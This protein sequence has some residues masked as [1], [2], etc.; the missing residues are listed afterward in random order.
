MDSLISHLST[1]KPENLD[2]GI[3]TEKYNQYLALLL[4]EDR[5]IVEGI[6][7]RLRFI[8]YEELLSALNRSLDDF[9]S[10][11]KS[12]NKV[13]VAFPSHKIGSENWLVAQV[14]HRLEALNPQLISGNAILDSNCE[15]YHILFIDDAIYTGNNWCGFI[16]S[17]TYD[18]NP[19]KQTENKNRFHYHVVVPFRTED[20]KRF[21]ERNAGFCC[22]PYFYQ[23]EVLSNCRNL[24]PTE[25]LQDRFKMESTICSPTYFAHKIANEFG[26]WPQILVDGYLPHT[27]KNFGTILK[28][29]P[30]KEFL[31]KK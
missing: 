7:S 14:W 6:I 26:C 3:D 2:Y 17:L 30:N 31:S 12:L 18:N 4:P 11:N 29:I 10:K 13:Y 22:I 21:I 24:F 20:S 1:V 23:H 28:N 16:D 25:E 15:E 8:S 27:G 9:L 19:E 5:V